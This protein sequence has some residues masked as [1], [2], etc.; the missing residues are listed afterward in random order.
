MSSLR[1]FLGSR[2][3]REWNFVQVC[4]QD[5][6]V[7]DDT[8]RVRVNFSSLKTSRSKVNLKFLESHTMEKKKS[9]TSDAIFCANTESTCKGYI[10]FPNNFYKVNE[11]KINNFYEIKE[12]CVTF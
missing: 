1:S 7:I 9:K 10:E 3:S 11:T 8:S 12:K 4:V 5:Q 6:S 2:F